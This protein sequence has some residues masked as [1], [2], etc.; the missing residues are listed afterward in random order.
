MLVGIVCELSILSAPC[1][2]CQ[3]SRLKCGRS[4]AHQ[5][6]RTDVLPSSTRCA[7]VC[8]K[9]AIFLLSNSEAYLTLHV[10][11]QNVSALAGSSDEGI[12]MDIGKA[13]EL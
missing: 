6:I 12:K 1:T 11:T 8:L 9:H 5:G 7:D 13:A 4:I 3:A 2:I 10:P